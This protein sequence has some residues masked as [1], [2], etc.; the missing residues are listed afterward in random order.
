MQRQE[1]LYIQKSFKEIKRFVK[2]VRRDLKLSDSIL[3]FPA[4]DHSFIK[5]QGDQQMVINYLAVLFDD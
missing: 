4:R 2:Q 3:K 5:S 1:I